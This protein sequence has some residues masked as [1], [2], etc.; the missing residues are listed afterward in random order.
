MR[1][2]PFLG[3]VTRPFPAAYDLGD[4]LDRPVVIASLKSLS[5]KASVYTAE[6]RDRFGTIIF[7]EAHHMGAPTHL[8][9]ASMFR[10][11]RFGLTATPDRGDGTTAL[12][13][14]HL[15][16][17]IYTSNY[18]PLTP[19]IRF[20]KAP[21]DVTEKDRRVVDRGGRFNHGLL[22]GVLGEEKKFNANIRDWV[23]K[24]LAEGRTPMVFTN[25][26]EH[27]HRLHDSFEKEL[28]PTGIITG[29]VNWDQREEE[30]LTND[31]IVGTMGA[32]REGLNRLQLDTVLITMPVGRQAQG[33]FLQSIWRALRD[34]KQRGLEKMDPLVV[35]MVPDIGTCYAM[36]KMMRNT[37]VEQ[38]Y[39]VEGTEGGVGRVREVSTSH[40]SAD[41]RIRGGKRFT[42]GSV[43]RGGPR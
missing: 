14:H 5:T 19:T 37:A 16:P 22:W 18:H 42:S 1:K 23:E 2:L 13:L 3:T 31:L 9:V 33:R 21:A 17:I 30:L 26:R 8:P 27:A 28:K 38:G 36:A 11:A 10:G 29:K 39:T 24:F 15:G 20:A 25:S 34:A 35:V 7:D 12:Y 43:R 6:L 32:A 40:R 41:G 4:Q